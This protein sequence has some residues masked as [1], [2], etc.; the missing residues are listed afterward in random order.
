VTDG[1]SQAASTFEQ[2]TGTTGD[3]ERRLVTSSLLQLS[4]IE[5]RLPNG[6]VLYATLDLAIE[7]GEFV[8]VMGESGIGKST[9]LN[10]V[11]GLDDVDGGVV[12]FEGRDLAGLDDD[13]RTRVRRDRMGF[14]FQAFHVLPHL[15][16]E[17]NVALPLVLARIARRDASTRANAMLDAVGL[18]GRGSDFPQ[19]LSGGELQRV[20]IARALI[21]RPALLLL[22]EPTGNLDPETAERVLDVID[23]Q[24]MASGATTLLVTHSEVAAAR[25][26]RVLSLR[27]TG[28]TVLRSS[29]TS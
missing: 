8:A 23:A 11:A 17:Q 24:R 13:A 4:A 28:L 21:H 2:E 9:L 12:R 5:K 26:D 10:I 27:S 1:S 20:A 29:E 18:T 6:R 16:V 22:D 15:T 19:V 14:V 3:I 25:A 7:A